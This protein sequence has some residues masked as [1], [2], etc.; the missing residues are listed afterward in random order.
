MEPLVLRILNSLRLDLCIPKREGFKVISK[1]LF[2]LALL[3]IV[4]KCTSEKYIDK[5]YRCS[6][7]LRNL[8]FIEKSNFKVDF[9]LLLLKDSTYVFS[10]AC[11]DT[12]QE[13]TCI[14]NNFQTCFSSGNYRF[15][16]KNNE[17][18]LVLFDLDGECEYE[19]KIIN[20]SI[21]S[22]SRWY[23][24]LIGI[25]FKRTYFNFDVYYGYY[26]YDRFYK[27][28]LSEFKKGDKKL[29]HPIYVNIPEDSLYGKYLH[30][31]WHE[32][33]RYLL[34]LNPNSSFFIYYCG[35]LISKGRWEYHYGQI[36][37][38]DE[39]ERFKFYAYVLESKEL[40]IINMP[41]LTLSIGT[42]KIFQKVN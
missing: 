6:H 35:R 41:L 9:E 17:I 1:L 34:H 4:Q 21:I 28:Y 20:D 19:F 24:N 3:F 8:P 12:S 33:Q 25:E 14:S 15:T 11:G 42:S 22:S 10:V 13:L 40:L 32:S 30:C 16:H 39:E 18:N 7:A 36:E 27:Q 23:G 5:A 2:T 38:I 29:V 37:L 26:G 31:I